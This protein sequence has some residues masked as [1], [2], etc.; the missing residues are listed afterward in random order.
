M[1][2]RLSGFLGQFANRFLRHHNAGEYQ[3][4]NSPLLTKSEIQLLL[5]QVNNQGLEMMTGNEVHYRH[6][7]DL[8][9]VYL[10]QGLDFEESRLYQRGDDLRNMDWRTTAR[11][12]KPYLKVYREEHQPEWHF[13]I[14]RSATMRFGTAKLLKVTQ[15]VRIAALMA[16]TAMGR[17]ACIGGSLAQPDFLFLPCLAGEAGAFRLV[18][19]AIAPAPPLH[20]KESE[21]SSLW[22]ALESLDSLIQRGARLVIISD[23]HGMDDDRSKLLL[24]LAHRH[25]LIPIQVQDPV[26]MHLPDV[27]HAFFQ[28]VS[29]EHR[30]L[31]TGDKAVRQAF[32]GQSKKN[33]AACNEFFRRIGIAFHHVLTTD[34][35]FELV[36]QI[37]A[38][39]GSSLTR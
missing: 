7:G 37:L 11:T 2:P 35:P 1:M 20:P 10:G 17:G 9:S 19:T 12:G 25:E 34:E 3:A 13:V 21:I 30:W 36:M 8:R 26:E 39:H 5:Q 38:G 31:D 28:N 33:R 23:F 24:R 6:A 14:D 16:Y 27:G 15:A 18:E 4:A 32:A 22:P 29:S